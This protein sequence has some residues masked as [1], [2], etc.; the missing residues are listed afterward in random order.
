[1]G[2]RRKSKVFG[3][4]GQRNFAGAVSKQRARNAQ[5][6]IVPLDSTPIPVRNVSVSGQAS[7]PC[8]AWPEE[9]DPGEDDGLREPSLGSVTNYAHSDQERWAVGDRRD[10]ELD[11]AAGIADQDGLDE[12]V[13]FRDWQGVGM[14]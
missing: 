2:G 7:A 1:V 12:Q 11:P 3:N 5:P 4:I 6:L 14:G 8:R 9:D 10:L 13:P